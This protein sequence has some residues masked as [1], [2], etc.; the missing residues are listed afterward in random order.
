MQR[1]PEQT[2]TSRIGVL[3]AVAFT[4]GASGHSVTAATLSESRLAE[5]M[6]STSRQAVSLESLRARD[7]QIL[8]ELAMS[9]A[10]RY[11]DILAGSE[12]VFTRMAESGSVFYRLDF[13]G[14]RN[15]DRARALCEILEMERCI[16]RVGDDRLTVLEVRSDPNVAAIAI[17]END[18][19]PF[20]FYG[21][22]STP[23]ANPIARRIEAGVRSKLDP[24]GVFPE[25]RPDLSRYLA[26]TIVTETVVAPVDP[27]PVDAAPDAG[28]PA[29]RL[30]PA[31]PD[32]DPAEEPQIDW[33]DE[34]VEGPAP[35]AEIDPAPSV[36][37]AP[38]GE[39]A[40]RPVPAP[41]DG[42]AS[43][44]AGPAGDALL[45]TLEAQTPDQGAAL[46][47][48]PLLRDLSTRM[49]FA[50][51][52]LLRPDLSDLV[53]ARRRLAA[54]SRP[55]SG[56]DAP[57]DMTMRGSGADVVEV[58]SIEA[59]L[60]AAPVAPATRRFTPTISI[61][62]LATID[63]S[64]LDR[65]G[66]SRVEKA[67]VVLPGVDVPLPRRAAE[68]APEDAAPETSA[69]EAA[70]PAPVDPVVHP[71]PLAR[72]P[73]MADLAE[74]DAAREAERRLAAG[75]SAPKPLLRSTALASVAPSPVIQVAEA[76][77][78]AD[79]PEDPVAAVLRETRP[80]PLLRPAALVAPVEVA[81]VAPAR[82]HPAPGLRPD[83]EE[84]IRIAAEHNAEPRAEA[85]L[86]EAAAAPAEV[87]P[88]EAAPQTDGI[89]IA[90][91]DAA[92]EAAP[93]KA[94][95]VQ[96]GEGVKDGPA[97]V[98]VAA[99]EADSV[100]APREAAEADA[101]VILAA[102][103]VLR[104]TGHAAFEAPVPEA[105]QVVATASSPI[106][107]APTDMVAAIEPEPAPAPAAKAA[108]RRTAMLAETPAPEA[109]V[110]I[111]RL[112]RVSFDDRYARPAHVDFQDGR[113]S[114]RLQKLPFRRPDLSAFAGIRTPGRPI[115]ETY[116]ADRLLS[117]PSGRSI[118][119]A[120]VP[121]GADMPED[122]P[123]EI[124]AP[125]VE[126]RS[127]AD[128]LF[129]RSRGAPGG[130]ASAAQDLLSEIRKSNARSE[131]AASGD[132]AAPADSAPILPRL[133][134]TPQQRVA[135]EATAPEAEAA[136][137]AE[138][139]D[140]EE[141]APAP[142]SRIVLTEDMRVD[143]AGA[144]PEPEKELEQLRRA[145]EALMELV[146]ERRAREVE[147]P[148]GEE[149]AR[150]AP[151]VTASL[152]DSAAAAEAAGWQSGLGDPRT[153]LHSRAH[154]FGAINPADMLNRHDPQPSAVAPS[155]L[156]IELSYAASKEQVLT[157]VT[158]FRR[159][160]PQ[161]VLEQ[162]RFFG[163]RVHGGNEEF[164]VGFAARDVAAR[165][166]IVWYLEQMDLP[167]KVR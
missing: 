137:D 43:E 55:L 142:A 159:I 102:A 41:G 90:Q 17:V 145:N 33:L 73:L 105:G 155:G 123:F 132:E 166:D 128:R 157:R 3:A 8:E 108:P 71:V 124:V 76:A 129:E 48:E 152:G 68:P 58:A 44:D 70:E 19:E 88:A 35:G 141:T 63:L 5:L 20:D 138:V 61:P 25:P 162:G 10:T 28:A 82:S 2:M 22:E 96:D 167:Y 109:S 165:D 121:G 131:E 95:A 149:R 117:D 75:R 31:L 143:T 23:E 51:V 59:G 7:R 57:Q 26:P 72:A 85:R 127:A 36:A 125:E 147:A 126:P 114:G 67:R 156:R 12:M 97:A 79:G 54:T 140:V 160:F 146:A 133:A 91:A 104:P 15:R 122:A 34:G 93:D 46:H 62:T 24:L 154:P 136:P 66:T 86:A 164:I 119:V 64:V 115:G 6:S 89:E 21:E 103:P 38:A 150:F 153:D 74:R 45:E 148:A 84:L 83:L 151:R 135:P 139:V 1:E 9:L 30:V 80:M 4:L 18:S 29:P 134:L 110:E 118:E 39:A 13:V 42:D 106:D 98:I 161:M 14:L 130:D 40:P 81:M 94:A 163:A 107:P 116:A 100:P 77:P 50:G 99:P 60:P 11:S 49:G 158:E 101:Q 113:A 112:G 53:P 32:P 27:A 78:E 56:P 65:S 37:P 120:Q 52:P 69:S 87:S 144:T 47:P 92:P 111:A 16:A